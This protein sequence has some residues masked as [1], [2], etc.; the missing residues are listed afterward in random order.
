KMEKA[1]LDAWAGQQATN[2][3]I[4]F[5][6]NFNGSDPT[7]QSEALGDDAV[8]AS[9]YGVANLKRSMGYLMS[10]MT[11]FGEEYGDLATFHGSLQSQFNR[12]IGHV[13]V[14]VGGVVQTDYH[15]GRGGN[16]Y[17]HVPK[18]RK[19]AAVSW[20]IDNVLVEP[21]WLVPNNIMLKLGNS[22]GQGFISSAQ[23]R[24]INGLLNNGRM[25]RM[26]DNELVNGP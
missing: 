15:A 6:D 1:T 3:L 23:N 8:M 19:K 10:G 16:V 5:Y 26:M 2:P 20:L 17:A 12:Y 22:S 4:R 21:T 14:M 7:A 25:G 13:Q 11:K 24:V 18:D 9:D